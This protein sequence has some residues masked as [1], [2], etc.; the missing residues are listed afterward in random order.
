MTF[1]FNTI[2][3]AI[4][5]IRAGKM[6]VV[7]DDE[8]RENEG[9]LVMAAEKVT[10]EAINFMATYGRG[11]ICMP[12]YGERL[13]ELNLPAMVTNN[14]DPH[15][16]AFTVSVDAKECTTGISA[17]ERALTV[18]KILDPGTK[19][20]DLRRPGHIFPLRAKPGG[21]LVRS[22]HTEAAVD[23]A[24]LAGLKSAGVICEIMKDDGTMARVPELMEFCQTHNLKIITI[25]DLIKYRRLHEKFIKKVESA[26]M[27]T[28]Y[29]DFIAVGYES[30]IDGKGHL[31]L[32]KGDLSSVEAPLVRV[33]SECLTGD[34]FGSRRCDCGDQLARA[35]Q[36]IE[37]EGVG[38]LLYMR[39][40]GRGIGLMN[41]IR[42]Y[43]LQDMG[44]DT[45]EANLAL[46]FP[47]DLRDY[48]IGAQIL[49]DLGLKKIRLLT[50][51]PRKIAGLE[52]YGL[53]VVD[54]VPIEIPAGK[55]NEK[56]LSTKKCK[57]GHMLT[58]NDRSKR[59]VNE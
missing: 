27:P 18:Q 46:G 19:P 41:K 21:V 29:G 3:E 54:R 13:D 26:Q 52:G 9:D 59:P 53:E 35:L 1:K 32:V 25:A 42:A 50:N 7:V 34:V 48:G 36:A 22:G 33:H 11:L 43:K 16:T 47:A 31:A 8:D 58:L 45:V 44:A 2:R 30:L 6:I 37:K 55:A 17:V 10:P 38:V 14:T 24:R 49:A 51:N 15:G 40:E 23:L 20:E 12:I 5:D 57:L 56:Y 39:Q 4:E 28:K